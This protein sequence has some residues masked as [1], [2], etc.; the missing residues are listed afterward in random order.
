MKEAE[1]HILNIIAGDPWRMAALSAVRDLDLP[2]WAVGAGFVRAAVWDAH[3]GY[4]VPTPLGDIDVVYFA[5][6]D[7]SRIRER[8]LEQVLA[9]SCP[10]LPWSVRNQARMHR[11]NGDRPY[12]DTTDAIAH[13]LETPTCVAVRLM[14]DDSL[15]LIAPHG[16]G[17]L[18]RHRSRPTPTGRRKMADFMG[19][20]RTK[21]W[22]AKWP[23]LVIRRV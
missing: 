12:R 1:D 20:V 5:P 3:Y 9:S 18:I 10:G 6:R 19:R 4:P 16:L 8:R 14:A 2:D 11:R 22:R 21:D 23:G 13:W 15:R 17:D 7:P